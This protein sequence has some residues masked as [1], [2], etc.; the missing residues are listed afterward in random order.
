MDDEQ[1]KELENEDEKVDSSSIILRSYP[2]QFVKQYNSMNKDKNG[3]ILSSKKNLKSDISL[4]LNTLNIPLSNNDNTHGS[5]S[6]VEF[7]DTI[8]INTISLFANE[9]QIQEIFP[10]FTD[11]DTMHFEILDK[12]YLNENQNISENN[13]NGD[14]LENE[15]DNNINLPSSNS[16]N[17]N[18]DIQTLPHYKEI[19][20]MLFTNKDIPRDHL[21][22]S[23]E[24]QCLLSIQ[25]FDLIK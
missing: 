19:N 7:E 18:N 9:D 3:M 15:K 6:S 14:S 20:L 13:E 4:P 24:L 23:P 17:N 25:P 21:L 5:I 12:T 11:G 1:A 8:N 2:Q 16:D 10:D 22:I